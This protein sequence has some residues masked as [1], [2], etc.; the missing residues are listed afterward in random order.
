MIAYILPLTMQKVSF[1]K[2][3]NLDPPASPVEAAHGDLLQTHA[4]SKVVSSTNL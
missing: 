1:V 2:P 4:L 3:Y